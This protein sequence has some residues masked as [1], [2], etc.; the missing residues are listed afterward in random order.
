[1]KI[2][3]VLG[4]PSKD[5]NTSVLAREV[6]RGAADG[7]AEIDEIFLAGHHIEF[8]RGCISRDAPN[9]CMST[10]KCIIEDD[11]NDFRQKLY[12][13]DGIVL[14]SPSYG[15]MPTARMKNFLVD[16][17]GMYTAYTSSLGGKY[18]VGV[19]TCGGIGAAGVARNL[20]GDFL[21]GF[22]KRGY[23]SGH[24]GVKLGYDRIEQKPEV[25]EQAYKLGGKLVHD[26]NKQKRYP[27]QR[28]PGRILNA[29]FLRRI[30]LSNIYANK[31]TR[32]KAVYN[33]LVERKLIRH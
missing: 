27:L 21:N 9:M 13:S 1:M 6:L 25:L 16:R 20:A 18:F 14:A 28:L 5:G 23:C 12:E 30:I 2:T 8:C 31:D 24:I 29:L 10:G 26:I 19:S 32:M 4:S 3:A 7:G 22:H 11:V 15:R 17:I 33:N